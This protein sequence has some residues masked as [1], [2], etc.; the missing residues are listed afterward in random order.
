MKKTGHWCEHLFFNY[1]LWYLELW[2]LD[3]HFLSH[4]AIGHEGVQ[5]L[6]KAS[7]NFLIH[8]KHI[9]WYFLFYCTSYITKIE[10]TVH[11]AC[12]KRSGYCSTRWLTWT[13]KWVGRCDSICCT[14]ES[15]DASRRGFNM[16]HALYDQYTSP[17]SLQKNLS[18]VRLTDTCRLDVI[19]RGRHCAVADSSYIPLRKRVEITCCRSTW[20]ELSY[21]L[22]IQM[23]CVAVLNSQPVIVC[24]SVY[25]ISAL[26]MFSEHEVVSH[27]SAWRVIQT[28]ARCSRVEDLLLS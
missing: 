25:Q 10:N 22:Y 24:E 23:L 14:E 3:F 1:N 21:I 6:F 8:F 20:I 12:K 9:T 18:S 16:S 7:W 5:A 4:L 26:A 15:F 13:T 27:Y 17:T 19:I 2:A 28:H 11:H